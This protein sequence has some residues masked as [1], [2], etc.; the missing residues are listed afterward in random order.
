MSE[1]GE[2][3]LE[4]PI[5]LKPRFGSWGRDVI[6]CRTRDGVERMRELLSR[7]PWFRAGAVAQELVPPRGFDL[8]LV[9]AAGRVVGAVRRIAAPGEWRTN[10]ALGGTRRSVTPTGRACATA[11]AAAAAVGADFVGV[12]L[13]PAS[14]ERYVVVELNGAVDFN[15]AYALGG[16]DPFR[17]AMRALAVGERDGGGLASHLDGESRTSANRWAGASAENRIEP[18]TTDSP[19]IDVRKLTRRNC[20]EVSIW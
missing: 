4:P 7:R 2:L 3:D 16:R 17:E 13:L 1:T 12:D 19:V 18:R 11:L 14:H 5:V 20:E 8:R 9:V 15:E 10:V 6:L